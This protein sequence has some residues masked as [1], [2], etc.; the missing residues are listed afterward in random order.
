MTICKYIFPG[1]TLVK[2][3]ERILRNINSSL[4]TFISY[5]QFIFWK[6]SLAHT[7]TRAPCVTVCVCVQ[8]VLCVFP[9]FF[10][11]LLWHNFCRST[12]FH[13]DNFIWWHS[14]KRDWRT[15]NIP[16]KKSRERGRER[17]QKT[18]GYGD[19]E[20]VYCGFCCHFSK[21]V[22]CRKHFVVC[23]FVSVSEWVSVSMCV[24]AIDDNSYHQQKFSLARSLTHLISSCKWVY[25]V[26]QRTR[27]N[28]WTILAH[29]IS[30]TFFGWNFIIHTMDQCQRVK[31]DDNSQSTH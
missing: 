1:N 21:T 18:R 8:L 17:E 30:L 26:H 12:H 29:F 3:V 20:H 4:D 23:H 10:F 22:I 24:C 31:I 13:L 16:K 11:W 9:L 15:V 2:I 6:H 27:I 5:A 7:H 28:Q 25:V 14:R 19:M